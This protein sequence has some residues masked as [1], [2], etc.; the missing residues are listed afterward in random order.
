VQDLLDDFSVAAPFS[1]P[2]VFEE[3][4]IPLDGDTQE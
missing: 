1:P 2:D 4:V 3:K